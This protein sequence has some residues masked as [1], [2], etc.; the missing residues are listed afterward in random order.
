VPNSDTQKDSVRNFVQ[1]L[2]ANDPLAQHLGIT[3]VDAGPGWATV[4]MEVR[5]LHLNFNGSCHGGVVFSLA[6]TAFGLAS[7]SYG[8]VAAG[9]DA[10]IAFPAPSREGDVLTAVAVEMSRSRRLAIYRVE[11]HAG[12]GILISVFTGTVYITGKSNMSGPADG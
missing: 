12:N 10:H 11:V 7:N 2:A 9:I 4:R 5:A 3:C 6:D 8:I 1:G